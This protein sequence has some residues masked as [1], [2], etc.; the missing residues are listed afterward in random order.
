MSGTRDYITWNKPISQWQSLHV[1]FLSVEFRTERKGHEIQNGI[2]WGGVE[3]QR[4]GE[5]R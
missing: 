1:Y 2:P 5:E 3:E 4:E